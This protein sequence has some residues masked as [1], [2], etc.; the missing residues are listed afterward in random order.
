MGLKALAVFIA[1]LL[2][3]AACGGEAIVSTPSPTTPAGR[4]TQLFLDPTTIALRPEETT[5]L[6]IRAQDEF[7][8]SL[9]PLSLSWSVQP[10]VG[11]ISPEGVFQAGTKA[12]EFPD[13]IKVTASAGGVSI[14][15]TASVII[16]PGPVYE[17]SV[18]VSES[19][20]YTGDSARFSVRAADRYGNSIPDLEVVWE[21]EGGRIDEAGMYSADREPGAFSATALV[22][23][24]EAEAQGV[25]AISVEQG[26]CTTEERE[27]VWDAQWYV[28]NNDLTFGSSLGRATYSGNFSVTGELQYG[29]VLGLFQGYYGEVFAGR[30]DGLGLRASSTVVVQRQGP[31]KFTVGGDDGYRLS[32]NN[33]EIMSDWTTHSY[34]EETRFLN[35]TPWDIRVVPGLFRMDGRGEVEF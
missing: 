8:N 26:Y 24:G 27:T 17:A 20:I 31:V 15:A 5:T 21:S 34:R 9:S 13:S 3:V 29:G 1:V 18:S 28:L 23:D 30:S 22:S 35:L 7:G 16:K 14:S 19:S 2:V 33:N 4:F 10:E 25:G 11:T 32:V 6:S 12:G